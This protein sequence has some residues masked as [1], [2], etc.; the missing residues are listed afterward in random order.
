MVALRPS[1]VTLSTGS[2]S[3]VELARFAEAAADLR[4]QAF[5]LL[6]GGDTAAI[7]R[8]HRSRRQQRTLDRRCS[9]RRALRSTTGPIP[10]VSTSGVAFSGVSAKRAR[11]APAREVAEHGAA[12]VDGRL[13]RPHSK[14]SPAGGVVPGPRA[15]SVLCVQSG[16]GRSFFGVCNRV[17]G[18]VGSSVSVA[19]GS[20]PP[21]RVR[22]PRAG[23]WTDRL[24][25]RSR[26]RER[27][28]SN[29]DLRMATTLPGSPTGG[30][31]HPSG[32]DGAVR[33]GEHV[34]G[35]HRGIRGPGE[36]RRDPAPPTSRGAV[37]RQ[38]SSTASSAVSCPNSR[39][40]PSHSTRRSPRCR[41]GGD[42]PVA[43]DL[44][45]AGRSLPRTRV[46]EST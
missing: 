20:L 32:E 15:P 22:P 16:H 19:V 36:M 8:D 34:R 6:R 28:P 24:R 26:P 1:A 44:P 35:S 29:T 18:S 39:G 41:Q 11:I 23:G 37:V 2:P 17:A 7:H 33:V 5:D 43:D 42:Q 10:D 21:A 45:V 30:Q 25:T 38:T 27:L 13:N 31:P 46:G 40:P 9:A 4:G 3:R 12:L 14:I